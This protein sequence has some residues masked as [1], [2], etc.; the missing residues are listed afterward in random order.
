MGWELEGI[1]LFEAGNGDQI[2]KKRMDCD[3]ARG[4]RVEP[5]P[6]DLR[7]CDQGGCLGRGRERR[8]KVG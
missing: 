8:C 6:P 2:R 5:E 4:R 3:P 1:R 7:V